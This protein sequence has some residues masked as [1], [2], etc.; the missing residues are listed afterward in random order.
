MTKQNDRPSTVTC[1]HCGASVPVKPRGRVP[2]FCTDPKRKCR[3][4]WHALARLCHL[5]DNAHRT[6]TREKWR[7]LKAQLYAAANLTNAHVEPR[8]LP[9]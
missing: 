7:G 1:L 4:T 2:E 6:Y 3:A 5:L 9:E 8:T